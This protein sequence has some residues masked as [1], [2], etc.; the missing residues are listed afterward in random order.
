[1]PVEKKKQRKKFKLHQQK[2][3]I[4]REKIKIK[5]NYLTQT[6]ATKKKNA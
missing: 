2:F 5:F 6:T 3:L 4:N 1:M